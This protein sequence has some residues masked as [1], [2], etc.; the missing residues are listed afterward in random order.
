MKYAIL[1]IKGSQYKVKEGA[2]ITVNRISAANN[3]KF[4]PDKILTYVSGEEFIMDNEGL[5]RVKVELEKISDTLGKKVV[6]RKFK[7]RKRYHKTQGH[8]QKQSLIK[9]N[10]ITK[11]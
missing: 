5:G 1:Q 8:R 6:I 10:K 3:K 11:Q 7:R 4:S 2:T 9:V